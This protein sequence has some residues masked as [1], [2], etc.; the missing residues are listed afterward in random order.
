VDWLSDLYPGSDHVHNLNL[1]GANDFEVWDYAK[2]HGF[3]IVSKNSDF[4]ARSVLEKEPPKI[5][6]IRLGNCS[7]GDVEI[8]LRSA[9]DMICGFLEEDEETCLL[10]GQA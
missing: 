6:W 9:P 4:A 5:I 10:V 7:T 1:G 8:L 2:L 3:A